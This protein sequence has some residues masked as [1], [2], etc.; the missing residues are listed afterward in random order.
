M[1]RCWSLHRIASMAALLSLLVV[2][3]LHSQNAPNTSD[4][5]SST[6]V[7]PNMPSPEAILGHRIILP[8]DG[9]PLGAGSAQKIVVQGEVHSGTGHKYFVT[10]IGTLGGTQSFAYAL[11][12]SGHLVGYSWLPG[13]TSGHSFLYSNGQMTD[14]SPLNSGN[15]VT[16]GPTGINNAGQIASG[17]MIGGVYVPAIYDSK[18]EKTT[19]LGT[20]GGG[21]ATSINNS[22]DA[23]GYSYL[24]SLT[25][26]A[27]L[28]SNGVMTDIQGFEGGYSYAF[29]INDQGVIVG[30]A[31]QDDNPDRA[32]FY[33]HGVMSWIGPATNSYARAVNQRGQI[34]GEFLTADN[35]AFHAFLYGNG[36]FT[37]LGLSG[38]PETVAYSINDQQQ[39]VGTVWIPYDSVCPY[40][41][42]TNYKQHAF[43]WENGNPVDLNNLIQED[44]GWE[45]AWAFDINN[46]GQIVGYG[47]VDGNFRA[48]L[49]TPAV[50]AKQCKNGS[51]SNFG[52][53]NEERCIHF[54]ETGK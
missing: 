49:L 32:F 53:Q 28:Y 30:S 40:G 18:T 16:V 21:V 10:D 46:R 54:V 48:F 52:F 13:D 24:D 17:L 19:L 51:W 27:F 23:V 35:S 14:L 11:N 33:A 29:G 8:P 38:S 43:L 31:S 1:T 2:P 42:C 5:T 22:G 41:P 6:S 7:P 12:D 34:V 3:C 39:I 26:H 36:S 45:L 37:D 47:L 25:R 44:S 15:V 4:V 50:S 9:S 20:L